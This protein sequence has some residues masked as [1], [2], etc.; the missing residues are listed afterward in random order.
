MTTSIQNPNIITLMQDNPSVDK[1]M[2]EVLEYM[3]NNRHTV[4]VVANEAH[5]S[6]SGYTHQ[7]RFGLVKDNKFMNI[8]PILHKVLGERMNRNGNLVIRSCGS[9]AVHDVLYRLY[10]IL[11][12]GLTGNGTRASFHYSNFTG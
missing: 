3:W 8:T 1:D 12:D 5:V 6:A 7:I 9:D 4:D 10:G 11:S 2:G